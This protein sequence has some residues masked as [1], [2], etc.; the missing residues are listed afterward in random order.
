MPSLR[1]FASFACLG[2]TAFLF[3]STLRAQTADYQ[4]IHREATVADGH[5]DVL[6]RVLQGDRIDVRGD[7]GHSDLPRFREGGLDVQV[8]SIW[9]HPDKGA[10][11]GW[12]YALR[13]IDSLTTLAER[14]PSQ[15]R[16]VVSDHGLRAAIDEGAIAGIIGLEGA[17]CIDGRP[18]RIRQLHARGLRVFAPTWNHSVGWASSSADEDAGRGLKGLTR[19]G[20]RLI[21]LLDTLGILLDVS[22][23]GAAAMKDAM[24]ETRL[25]VIASHSSCASLRTHH[26]NLTDDQL[27]TV[28]ATGGVVMIN[29]FPAFNRAGMTDAKIELTRAYCRKLDALAKKH[30]KRDARFL[31]AAD[32]LLRE[33]AKKGLPTLFDIADHIDHAVRTA[34]A[35][36]VGLGSDFD[37]ISYAP[38]GLHD[39]TWLPMLTRELLRRGHSETV[40]KGILGGNFLRVFSSLPAP[41]R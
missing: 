20:R 15:I 11:D 4:R 19:H 29:F 28:A 31:S 24:E 3:V 34:G 35:Q 9:V 13:E 1:P 33:A 14:N 39:V 16:L 27:R 10:K 18:E 8:F 2:I 36:H 41:T 7:K 5:N 32:A 22:H 25:P 38:I 30:P 23:L 6:G 26:R 40:V 37:G 17:T 21:R 12:A